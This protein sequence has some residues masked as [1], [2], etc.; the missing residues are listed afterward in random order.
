MAPSVTYTAP[1]SQAARP[2]SRSAGVNQWPRRVDASAMASGG[3]M[4]AAMT[5]AMIV[6]ASGVSVARPATAKV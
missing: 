3:T 2:F 5:A 1:S 4:P 6:C